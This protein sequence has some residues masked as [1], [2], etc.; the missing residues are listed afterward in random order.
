MSS[1]CQPHPEPRRLFTRVEVDASGANA[2]Y[3]RTN[4]PADA[5]RRDPALFTENLAH[6][7]R[8]TRA[9]IDNRTIDAN[10]FGRELPFLREQS[11]ALPSAADL[12]IVLRFGR[13]DDEVSALYVGRIASPVAGTLTLSLF[14]GTGG[15]ALRRT[16]AIASPDTAVLERFGAVRAGSASLTFH[17][18]GSSSITLTD[19]RLLGQSPAL[20]E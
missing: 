16:I 8:L 7:S 5:Y 15:E 12:Q 17:S 4:K 3:R 20:R 6:T 19:M 11:A 18:E 14:D 9:S 10:M 13:D 2:I 1:Q